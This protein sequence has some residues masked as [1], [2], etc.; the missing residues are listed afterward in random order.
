MDGR[1]VRRPHGVQNEAFMPA[2]PMRA[3]PGSGPVTSPAAHS[4]QA[5]EPGAGANVA[6][7]QGSQ[8]AVLGFEAKNPGRH[9]VQLEAPVP[10][11]RVS[12]PEGQLW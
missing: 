2:P 12:Y 5:L 1:K 3:S 8:K 11:T 4:L 10:F 6:G 9:M 7:A